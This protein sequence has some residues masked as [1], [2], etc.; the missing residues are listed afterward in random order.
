M[1]LYIAKDKKD[2]S[3][4]CKGSEMCLKILEALPSDY[5]NIQDC[6][7]LKNKNVNFPKWLDGTPILIS[8]ING[9]IYKGTGALE[10]L[11]D[12][13]EEYSEQL[14]RKSSDNNTELNKNSYK[15]EDEENEGE[16]EES[17]DPW[18]IDNTIDENQASVLES[19]PKTTQQDV[20]EFMRKRQQSM[21]QVENNG[22][23]PIIE[24]TPS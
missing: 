16:E 17:D 4:Y 8:K 6:D 15:N 22:N 14:N 18:N 13:L 3:N 24:Q 12:I 11:R 20:E 1:V 2:P 23:I 5:I 21:S 9:E 10:F 7:K 19:K